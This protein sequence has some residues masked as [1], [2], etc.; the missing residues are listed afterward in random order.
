[1]KRLIRSNTMVEGK[2]K[3]RIQ[4]A[5]WIETKSGKDAIKFTLRDE[6][7]KTVTAIVVLGNMHGNRIIDSILNIYGKDDADL[8]D[9]K[10]IELIF[11]I[12]INGCF[13]NIKN[14]YPLRKDDE[15]DEILEDDEEIEDEDLL[16]QLEED[17][18]FDDD[19]ED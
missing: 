1:M 6:Q 15:E 16:Y 18:E 19:L 9:L 3:G 17:E 14:V 4:E 10:G 13:Y 5:E 7:R 2:H 11:E 8:N 12:D